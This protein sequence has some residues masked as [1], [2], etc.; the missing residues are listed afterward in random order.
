MGNGGSA[1]A[2]P[3][4]NCEEGLIL[5]ETGASEVGPSETET[6]KTEASKPES[7]DVEPTKA[8]EKTAKGRCRRRRGCRR[9]GCRRD[10]FATYFP[11]VL[12]RVHTGLRLLHQAVNVLDSF[13]KDMFEQIAQE[14][15]RLARST[16]RCTIV[17][18][19][20]QTAVRVLL[21]GELGKY[22]MSE[23]TKSVIRYNT[24]R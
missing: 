5:V 19:D 22:A 14:T 21:P 6:V 10:S 7:Y 9:R 12:K 4:D 3:S 16:R 11:R 24:R 1:M 8:K 2:Q 17:N 23:A 20:I 18:R 13:V 15:G